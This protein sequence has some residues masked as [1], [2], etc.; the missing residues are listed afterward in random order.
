MTL[1][2]RFKNVIWRHDI[3]RNNEEDTIEQ[4]VSIT[5]EQMI[6]F[7]NWMFDQ[8]LVKVDE[9]SYLDSE[10]NLVYN[11]ELLAE[12]KKQNKL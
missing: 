9:G 7:N 10:N 3:A 8:E 5:D 12:Y 6:K 1:E 2:E 4:C 11:T